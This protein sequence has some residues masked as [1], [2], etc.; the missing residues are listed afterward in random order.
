MQRPHRRR[1]G[2]VHDNVVVLPLQQ[3]GYLPVVM[4][5]NVLGFVCEV[6]V[7]PLQRVVEPFGDLKKPRLTGN[8]TP[9]SVDTQRPT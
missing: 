8:H 4:Q 2:V 9:A 7:C 6:K 3:L 1:L 5:I